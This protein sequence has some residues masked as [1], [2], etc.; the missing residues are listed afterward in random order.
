M[1]KSSSLRI[2]LASTAFLSLAGS[3]FALDGAD[4]ATKLNAAYAANG[5]KIEYADVQVDGTTVTF[6]G[7]KLS[8]GG[9]AKDSIAIG[10]VVM[11]GVEENDADGYNV[12]T[13]KFADVDYADAEKNG[14]TIK[15]IAIDGLLIPGKAAPGTIDGSILYASAH[16]GPISIKNKGV[17]VVTANSIESTMGVEDDNSAIDTTLKLTGFKA[18]MTQDND[19]KAKEFVDGLG[20]Q[21][22]TGDLNVEGTWEVATGKIDVSTLALDLTK[23]GRLDVNFTISGYT[24]DF[25]NAM[26]EAMKASSANA[27]KAAGQQALGMAMMGLMQQLTFEGAAIRFDDASITKRVLDYMGKQQNMSGDDM[28]KGAAAM[29]PMMMGQLNMPELQTQITEAA[30]TYLADP[31]NIEIT[32]EPEKPVPFPQIMGAAMGAPT[33]LPTVLGVSVTANQ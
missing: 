15:G 5:G 18:D 13:V 27:D 33:T 28:A 12:E 32:A 2:L 30:N 9:D 25:I 11:S 1:K 14:A 6:K 3:A 10:D 23:I 17:E 21:T 31:K 16:T 22:I 26:S 19:P 24:T 29:V 4:I 8:G 7:V 20:L